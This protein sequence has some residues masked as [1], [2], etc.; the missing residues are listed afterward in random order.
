MDFSDPGEILFQGIRRV[1][2]RVYARETIVAEE[3][4]L[5]HVLVF[6]E[7]MEQGC[8]GGY[9]SSKGALI[10]GHELFFRR[11]ETAIRSDIR[12]MYGDAE[13]SNG[14]SSVIEPMRTIVS[15]RC[16]VA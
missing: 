1:S 2:V 12:G 16:C 13:L 8:T 3:G 4:M 7:A 14:G 6:G 10:K 5:V 15:L 11:G 9:S